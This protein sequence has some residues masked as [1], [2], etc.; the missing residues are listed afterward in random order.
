[1]FYPMFAMILLTTIIGLIAFKIRYQAV[2]NKELGFKYFQV[3]EGEGIPQKVKQSTRCINNMFEVPVL[4]Y[5][6]ATL[7]IVL[8][9]TGLLQQTLA[10]GFVFFRGIHAYILLTYNNVLHRMLAYWCAFFSMLSMW[11]VVVI[12]IS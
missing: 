4:F 11:F 12:N 9:E 8:E 6:I 7:S 10:W 1:M 2:Q 3:M 5:V